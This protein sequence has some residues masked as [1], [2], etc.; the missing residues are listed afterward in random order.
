MHPTIVK[1]QEV[2]A[3]GDDKRIIELL[4]PDVV[5]L[6]PTYW[7]SWRGGRSR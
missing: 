3:S 1:M 5:F 2:V 4:S 7:A 6:P